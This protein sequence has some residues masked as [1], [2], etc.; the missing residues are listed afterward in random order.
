MHIFPEN[1]HL[2]FLSQGIFGQSPFG[3]LF[4]KAWQ[5]VACLLHDFHYLVKADAM[6]AIGE[7]GEGIGVQ[8]PGSCE[9]VPFDA[10]YLHQP[11]HRVTGQS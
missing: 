3:G 4:I 5:I 6:P 2:C 1:V 7:V 8:R 11:T 10:R 9:G